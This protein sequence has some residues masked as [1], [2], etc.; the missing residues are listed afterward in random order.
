MIPET[1]KSKADKAV[2]HFVST[3]STIRTSRANTALVENISV[4]AYG[5]KMPMNQVA[6]LS[7]PDPK[8]ISISV[9]D[10]TIVDAVIDAI[11]KAEL[12][13]N[14]VTDG[15]LI[16][17]N[18]SPM[19]EERRL[20]MVKVVAKYAEETRIALRNVRREVLDLIKKNGQDNKIPET[21]VKNQESQVEKL[22]KEYNE[23]VEVLL[24]AKQEE[25][26]IL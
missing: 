16:R 14:P 25:L 26:M 13:I 17:L 20:E 1:F 23:K 4:D 21:E 24:K 7:A 11:K 5:Q 19:T 8:L 3:L 22:M 12:G 15:N 18:I 2:D 10:N 6:T 9:W